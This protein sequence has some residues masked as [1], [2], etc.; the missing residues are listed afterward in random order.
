[1]GVNIFEWLQALGS[2]A[3]PAAKGF[4]AQP[5][6]VLVCVLMPVIIG[7]FVGYGLRFIERTFGV[8]LGKGG[9]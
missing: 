9:H 4:Q 6:Y 8:E 5:T 2:D 3:N 7:L 1:V